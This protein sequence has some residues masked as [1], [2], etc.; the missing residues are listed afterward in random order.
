MSRVSMNTARSA[1]LGWL[2]AAALGLLSAPAQ[3][4]FGRLLAT[5]GLTNIEGAGGG[6]IVPWATLASYAD[7]QQWGATLAFNVADVDDY[8][9]QVGAATVTYDNRWE[10][11]YARQNF[12]LKQLGG[13]LKQSI[14]G[15]KYRLAG[16]VIYGAMPQVSIG[17]QHKRSGDFSLPQAL[18][19]ASANGTDLY[20]SAT[21]AWL[22]G[23]WHRTWLANLTVRGTRANELGL[24]GFGGDLHNNYQWVAEASVAM[25]VNRHWVVGMEYRQKPDNLSF[26][27][28]Q[29][30]YDVFVG[31]FPSKRVAVA[32]AY[33]DLD[34]IA[35]AAGQTGVYGSLQ[36]S[37]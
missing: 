14:Y 34:A 3:A 5:G 29:D 19:A 10:F 12:E 9:L 13:E 17:L 27:K 32:L 20:V 18:G 22:D 35:G 25:F 8:Q 36:I 1:K 15:L 24:L 37:F 33:T 31:W 23:P 2:V 11:S 4:E 6:G 21:K 30:W 26:A 28:E 7:Q 16:D